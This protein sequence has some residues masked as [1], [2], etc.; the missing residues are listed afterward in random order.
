MSTSLP[1]TCRSSD[2]SE[3]WHPSGTAEGCPLHSQ[4]GVGVPPVTETASAPVPCEWFCNCD[5]EATGMVLHPIL[6]YVATCTR[7]AD[8]LNLARVALTPARLGQNADGS[9]CLARVQARRNV[10]LILDGADPVQVVEDSF[11][12]LYEALVATGR[13]P[14]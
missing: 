14:R 7:C 5:R 1:C 8:M 4:P 10:Q 3:P 6:G 12:T 11:I 9:E 13:I 2:P